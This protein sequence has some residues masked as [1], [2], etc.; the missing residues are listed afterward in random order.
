MKNIFTKKLVAMTMALLMLFNV[1]TV[2]F[3][4]NTDENTNNSIETMSTTYLS[5][6]GSALISTD[7]M[8]LDKNMGWG[9]YT[10]NYNVSKSAD[11]Y[12]WVDSSTSVAVATL[13]GSGSTQ[14]S[15]PL[16]RT[17]RSWQ[18]WVTDNSGNFNYS[19]SITK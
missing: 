12:L 13:S 8:A 17:Y 5:R 7:I 16:F 2:A 18:L 11:L 10:I 3:A 6:S 1:S 19:I 14:I 9:T 4:A 15:V